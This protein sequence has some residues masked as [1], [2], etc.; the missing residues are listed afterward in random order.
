MAIISFEDLL[1]CLKLVSRGNDRFEA[2]PLAMPYHRIYGG[3]LLAQALIAAAMTTSGK[4]P[5]S[6]HA[7]FPREGDLSKPLEL[8]VSRLHEGRSFA[9]RGVVGRQDGKVIVSAQLSLDIPEEGTSHQAVSPQSTGDPESEPAVDQ[10]MNPFDT[11]AV[12]G[13][14]LE[15]REA[16]KPAYAFWMK[17]PKMDADPLHHQA[18][19]AYAADLTIIG[20]TLRAYPGISEAD[21]PDRLLTAVTT[22]SMWFHRPFRCDEWL[23]FEQTSPTSSGARGFGQGHVF[24]REGE[25]VASFAQESM[26]RRVDG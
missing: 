13:V 20:T 1:G 18:V 9:S 26:I 21:V 23:L 15:Q 2:P 5:K 19:L 7:L 17:A 11:R 25:L 8:E 12:G 3:Q 22:N 10:T 14:D 24:D 16:G 6:L 4:R